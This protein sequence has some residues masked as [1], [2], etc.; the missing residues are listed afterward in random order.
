[1]KI[2]ATCLGLTLCLTLVAV[3][4]AF[5]ETS[6]ATPEA[7]MESS[8]YRIQTTETFVLIQTSLRKAP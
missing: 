7:S 4:P 3:V 6:D 2:H 5:S 1:M 8:T